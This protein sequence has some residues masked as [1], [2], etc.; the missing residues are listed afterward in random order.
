MTTMLIQKVSVRDQV[1]RVLTERILAGHYKPG[2]RLV[3][4]Q[5]ARELG[6]SQGSVREALRELEASRL[7]ES[8]PRRGTRVRVVSLKELQDAY[9]AR[10]ILEQAAAATAGKAFKGNV[11]KLREEFQGMLEAAEARDLGEQAAHV[12]ALHRM[13]VEASGNSVLLRLW[14]SLAF[15]TRVRVRLESAID[16]ELVKISYEAIF[17]AL[18]KGDSRASARLLLEHAASLAPTDDGLGLQS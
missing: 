12:Y 13:I 4:L 1:R 18:E 9:F 11:G 17:A 15:E 3:E 16:L 8:E 5:I 6:T 14:E 2:D 7:V 10:G